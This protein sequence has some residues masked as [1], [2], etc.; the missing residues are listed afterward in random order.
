M[1]SHRCRH[2]RLLALWVGC[3]GFIPAQ[4]ALAFPSWIGVYGAYQRH[5]DSVNPGTFTILMNQSYVGLHAEV[6]VRVDS[7]SW[8]TYSM[9]YN[10]NVGSDSKWVYTPSASYPTGSS[11]S[12]YFHGYDDWGG[13]IYDNNGGSNYSFTAALAP[14]SHTGMGANPF[15]GGVAFRVW[16]PNATS[17]NVAGD[18]NSWSTSANALASEGAGGTWSVDLASAAIGDEY[19]FVIDGSLWRVDPWA[20]QVTN[21]VGNGIIVDDS[22]SFGS[23][24]GPN[25]NDM[26]IYEMHVGTFND[27][28]GGNPGT[29]DTAVSKLNHLQSMGVNAVEVMPICE[30]AGDFSWGYNPAHPFAPESAYGTPT[31]MRDF[32]EECHDRGIAVIVD[33]VYNHWGPSDL[34]LWRF[35]GW[36]SNNLGGIYFF[37]DWR[38]STPW[39]DTRPDYGRGE[40]RTYIRDNAIRWL[41]DYNA[42]GLRW[43]STVNIRTQNNGGGGDISDGWSLM[44]YVNNEI[45]SVAAGKISIAE[46]LQNNAWLTKTTGAGGAGFDSQWDADF[47]HPIRSAIIASSDSSR[48]M[49]AVRDAITHNYNSDHTQRVIYTESHDEVANGKARVPEEIWPGNASSWASKKRST[50][51][52]AITFTSPGIPMIFQGQEFL[53][54]GYFQDTDPV[55]WSKA[56]T[57]SGITDLYSDLIYLRRNQG[58]KTAGLAGPYVNVHHI[59]NTN[60]VIA[61]HRWS[62]GGAA[63]DV[64]VVANF[65]STGYSG[66]NVGFPSSGTWKVRFNSD[67]NGYDSGFGNWASSNVTAS[68][69]AKD[70]MSYNG[71]VGVGP[72]TVVILSKD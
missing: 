51:G 68:Y 50:L 61:Y 20:K 72:Y 70:G 45:N 65:S 27:T 52:A 16:A 37:Q 66:Y 10:G 48:D 43:D 9:S 39:G 3:L 21:S 18:F 54:D 46:D 29:W 64:I 36:Y 25:W 12:Y 41:E 57:Y 60:K 13:H 55:D 63:D 32:V 34:D 49:Y 44:Q 7:G 35:D 71:N 62:S 2:V 17:V 14:S 11:I 30:F 26:V 8:Q 53:E 38:A 6:G 67:W 40:V 56:T 28:A 31:D 22:Y 33:V 42:D 58:G 59:N 19:Q 47:V 23:F 69:G 4:A 24:T 15:T 1:Q 5:T